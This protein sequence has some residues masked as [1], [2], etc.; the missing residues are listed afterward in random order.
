MFIELMNIND[1]TIYDVL[2][3]VVSSEVTTRAY[4]ATASWTFFFVDAVVVFD[5]TS[6]ELVQTV[7][8][9]Q[10]VFVDFGADR[11]QKAFFKGVEDLNVDCLVL[12]SVKFQFFPVL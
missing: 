11:T 7:F 12:L 6:A 8:Y 4:L 2:Q 5:A 1:K 3:L 9:V 10:G